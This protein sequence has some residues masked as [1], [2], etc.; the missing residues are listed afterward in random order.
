MTCLVGN[1]QIFLSA[2]FICAEKSTLLALRATGEIKTKNRQHPEVENAQQA[3]HNIL[4]N[5]ELTST[6]QLVL[7]RSTENVFY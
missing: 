3:K 7:T 5:I 2:V 4:F 1:K 6:S